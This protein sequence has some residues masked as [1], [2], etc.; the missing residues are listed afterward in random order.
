MDEQSWWDSESRKSPYSTV[1]DPEDE[2]C[3]VCG[4]EPTYDGP[5]DP[6]GT[7]GCEESWS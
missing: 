5:D 3:E 4:E 6:H 2:T 7:C 1:A